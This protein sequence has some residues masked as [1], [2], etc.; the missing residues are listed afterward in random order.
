MADSY[1]PHTCW[2][3]CV[4]DLCSLDQGGSIDSALLVGQKKFIRI[5]ALDLF[6]CIPEL[7]HKYYS[8]IC[9]DEKVILEWGSEEESEYYEDLLDDKEKDD[10]DG[11]ADDE[12]NDH[13]S[14][15]QDADDEDAET[16][17]DEDEIYKYKISKADAEKTSDVK[18]DANKAQIPS[19]SS[20]LAVSSGFGVQFLKLSFDSSLVSI[21]KDSTYAEINSLLEVKIQSEVPHI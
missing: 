18:D 17:S 11:D 6:D 20:S 3:T 4:V 5:Y 13:I 8:D 12:G 15:T 1:D 21:V 16:K 7:L 9:K 10:K 14:D 2:C 19:I